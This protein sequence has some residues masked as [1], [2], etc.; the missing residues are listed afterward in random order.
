MRSD[1]PHLQ[2]LFD[3]DRR[4]LLFPRLHR[5]DQLLALEH[6]LG[7]DAYLAFY[8]RDVG[9]AADSELHIVVFLLMAGQA[10]MLD[11]ALAYLLL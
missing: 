2:T 8:W 5:I 1:R 11:V 4:R 9:R 6:I 10:R 3:L 7:L